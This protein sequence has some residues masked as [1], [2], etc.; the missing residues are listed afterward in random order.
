MDLR[1]ER[2]MRPY[3]GKIYGNP[4]ALH[5]FGQEASA[6][7]FNARQKIAE[8]LGCHYKEIIFT[9]GATEANNLALRGAVKNISRPKII[10]LAIEHESVLETC[11]ELEREGVEVVYLPVDKKGLADLKKFKTALD[12]RTILVSI[13]YANNVIGT[14]QP[15]L[16]ISKI[17]SEFKKNKATNNE[18]PLF[19]TDAAQAFNYLDCNVSE[20]GVDLMTLSSQKIYGPKGAGLLYISKKAK[21]AP[22]IT[23]GGQESGL[24]GGTENVPGI[25]G[26]A[27]A[28]EIA[29][30][31]RTK[32]SSRLKILQQYFL[33]RTNT[34]LP[35]VELNGDL[36]SRLPNNVNLYFSGRET[37]QDLIIKLDLAGFAVSPG[38]AC[39]ARICKPS[40]VLKA[41]GYSDQRASGSLRISFGRQTDKGQIDKLLETLK[42]IPHL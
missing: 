23:G 21:I 10:T 5:W 29:D 38:A 31:E 35:E 25:V 7:V 33:N 27:K 39:A 28:M 16:K 34:I 18:Y 20:L 9:S 37:A 3:F 17:I 15:I 36:E 30:K 32:E 11:L 13:M 8:I 6:A 42:L 14:I 40:H 41:L 19:H 26:L 22:I 4:G 12:G 1:V 2:A 24:R